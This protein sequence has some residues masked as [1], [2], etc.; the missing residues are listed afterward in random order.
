MI[1]ADIMTGETV[2]KLH[3][4]DRDKKLLFLLSDLIP[5]KYL[6]YKLPV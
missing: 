5:W 2:K 1:F 4:A 3:I 6:Y